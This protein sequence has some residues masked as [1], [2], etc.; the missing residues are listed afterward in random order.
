MAK[1][2][3]IQGGNDGSKTPEPEKATLGEMDEKGLTDQEQ[4]VLILRGKAK[5]KV[6][7]ALEFKR[8]DTI[9]KVERSDGVT[10]ITTLRDIE[11]R[12]RA[13]LAALEK[14]RTPKN[15]QK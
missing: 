12:I 1:L 14:G 5:S 8:G 3:L 2:R 11:R 4:R 6:K 13:S 9:A 10:E 15:S 7:D